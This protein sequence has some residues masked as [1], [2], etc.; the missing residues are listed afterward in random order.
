MQEL[1][2]L[3]QSTDKNFVQLSDGQYLALTEQFR[4]RLAE[5][6]AVLDDKMRFSG[7]NAELVDDFAENAAQLKADKYWEQHLQ[8]LRDARAYQAQLPGTFQAELRPYQFEGFQWLSQLAHWGVGACLA[9]DMGLGKTIQALAVLVDRASQGPALVVA[10]VSVTRNWGKEAARFAPTLR[11]QIFGSGDRK[12]MLANLEAFD[13]LVSSYNLLQI[14]SEA[15]ENKHFA[16]IILD[17]AQAIK[18]RATKRSKTVVNLKGDFKIITTGTPVENH[19]GELWNLFQFINPGLLGG[20]DRFNERFANPIEKYRD[21]DRRK[22][23][24]KIVKPFILRRRKN[25]VLDKLPQKTEIQLTVELSPEERAFYEALRRDAVTRIESE[26]GDIQDKRFR[27]LAELTKLRLASCHPKLVQPEVPLGS[28]KLDLFVEIV[29][30]LLENN[31]KALV[32][33]QFVKHLAIIEEELK[34]RKN[35]L[36]IPGRQH[37]TP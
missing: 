28:S 24:Q 12:E 25:Q 17:E 22:Q 23:L 2:K 26:E 9:D 35:P 32:F 20:I 1:T 33:S 14:E 10:P 18:N 21:N 16:T 19:L 15:F 8:K 30:E 5:L 11:F 31:H 34:K 3:L 13:V 6:N 37:A 36:S 7:L 4:K 27:I 29:E